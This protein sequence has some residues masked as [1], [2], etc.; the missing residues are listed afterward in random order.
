MKSC[1]LRVIVQRHQDGC[2][3][4]CPDSCIVA[5]RNTQ[6]LIARHLSNFSNFL[7]QEL[8]QRKFRF[9]DQ[10]RLRGVTFI[11]VVVLGI[12]GVLVPSLCAE[13]RKRIQDLGF[14]FLRASS[15]LHNASGPRMGDQGYTGNMTARAQVVGPPLDYSFCE[16]PDI[17]SMV[18]DTPR[19]GKTKAQV[20]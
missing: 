17:E 15:S 6:E 19:S 2:F 14:L 13:T 10:T 20:A 11:L 12:K 1:E 3:Y 7:P 9:L 16:L 5:R 4:S 8:E 18:D